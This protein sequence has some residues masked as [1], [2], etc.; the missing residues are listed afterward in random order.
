MD[1]AGTMDNVQTQSWL[2]SIAASQNLTDFATSTSGTIDATKALQNI[3]WN[4]EVEE[5]EI[6]KRQN[7]FQA[8]G[9]GGL[10]IAVLGV[11]V[12]VSRKTDK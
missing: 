7:L 9:W 2:D 6:R 5:T 4:Q 3:A 10:A 11:A 12:A 8:I 1:L